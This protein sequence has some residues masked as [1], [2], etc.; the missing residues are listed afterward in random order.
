[1]AALLT[2]AGGG[3]HARARALDRTAVKRCFDVVGAVVLL[4][5]TLPLLVTAAGATALSSRGPVLF[6][7]TRVGRG[8]VPFTLLKLRTMRHGSDDG[9]HRDYVTRLLS[10]TAAPVDGLYK[11][12]R[13]ERVTRV[14]ALLRRSSLDELPQLWN[15]LRGD[16]SLVGPRP[17]LHWEVELFPAWAQARFQV[18]PGLTGLWQGSGRNRLTMIEGLALDVLYVEEL[19]LARDVAI[20]LRTVRAVLLPGAR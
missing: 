11:L 3:R 12:S 18:R 1:M 4:V 2:R 19:S 15:V 13:D 20:L 17:S 6:R 10:G 7:Q 14:G 8:G 9:V 16:M 5:L